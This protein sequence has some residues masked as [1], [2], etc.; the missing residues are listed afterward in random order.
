MLVSRVA[1]ERSDYCFDAE[2]FSQ[3]PAQ[4]LSGR[5]TRI[6]FAAGQF[7]FVGETPGARPLGNQDFI[8]DFEQGR[9]DHER[10]LQQGNPSP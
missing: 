6:H 2:F 10:F 7:P 4:G 5:F 3:F 1:E 8:R 9:G